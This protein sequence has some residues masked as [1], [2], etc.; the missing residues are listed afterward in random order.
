MSLFSSSQY[1][2]K[3]LLAYPGTKLFDTILEDNM[4]IHHTYKRINFQYKEIQIGKLHEYL[5]N[6]FASFEETDNRLFET[7]DF[8]I[9]LQ[10]SVT[11][12]RD[13]VLRNIATLF[14]EKSDDV[15]QK[16]TD[17]NYEFFINILDIFEEN[18]NLDQCRNIE[19]EFKHEYNRFFEP[20]YDNYLTLNKD[21]NIIRRPISTCVP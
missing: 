21:V 3:E 7:I 2:T 16:I 18:K 11:K 19:Q 13:K 12:I 17:L 9:K 14:I 10:R 8:Q 5:S 6:F 4:F 15:F 1:Y 20:I